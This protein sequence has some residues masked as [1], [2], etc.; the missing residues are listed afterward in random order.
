MELTASNNT[1]GH[2]MPFMT[3]VK[4]RAQMGCCGSGPKREGSGGKVTAV[5]AGHPRMN[6]STTF[7]IS[8]NTAY[9]LANSQLNFLEQGCN[10]IQSPDSLTNTCIIKV[11][12]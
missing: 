6:I 4:I 10:I 1:R 5:V 3:E 12:L 2:C 9:I 11:K 7:D 8:G